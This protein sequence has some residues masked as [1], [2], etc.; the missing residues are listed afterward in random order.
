MPAPISKLIANSE[1]KAS[2]SGLAGGSRGV[3][4][5]GGLS[6]MALRFMLC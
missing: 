1:A 6:G 5:G 2:W 3:R 4:A